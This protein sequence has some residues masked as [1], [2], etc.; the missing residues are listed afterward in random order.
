MCRY[1]AHGIVIVV[2][3]LMCYGVREG[4]LSGRGNVVGW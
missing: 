4:A 3:W 2:D 1:F